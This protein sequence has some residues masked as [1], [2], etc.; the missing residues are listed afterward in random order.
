VPTD[1]GQVMALD[2]SFAN[3]FRFI[4][5]TLACALKCP[6]AAIVLNGKVMALA[7]LRRTC[8]WRARPWD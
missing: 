1:H 6:R 3:M 2:P 4:S 8:P 7:P 5:Q